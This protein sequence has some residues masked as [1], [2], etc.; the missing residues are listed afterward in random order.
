VAQL[1]DR[2]LS[3]ARRIDAV[4]DLVGRLARWAVLFD[5]LVAS[6][7]A[8]SRKFLDLT[9]NF[10][11]DLQMH[12]L[13]VMVLLMAGYTLKRNEHVRIDILS[14]R[15]GLRY[16]AG[17]DALGCLLVVVPLS[18]LM[19]IATWPLFWHALVHHEVSAEM[20]EGSLPRWVLT[21]LLPLGFALLALQ[22]LAEAIKRVAYLMGRPEYAPR[23][24]QLIDGPH[25]R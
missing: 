10:A 15:F 25:S 22:A 16:C 20:I 23:S 8:L 21:S 6:G 4:T 3:L 17:L 7:N 18:L 14:G 2:A 12:F 11:L 19:V 1:L 9:S 13:A 24:G 5:V